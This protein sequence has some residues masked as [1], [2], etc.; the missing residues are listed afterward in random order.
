MYSS[1]SSNGVAFSLFPTL[2]SDVER[3]SSCRIIMACVGEVVE[4]T[5]DRDESYSVS[6]MYV[7]RYYVSPTLLQEFL[8]RNIA[9]VDFSLC[10]PV[11]LPIS[12]RARL[13]ISFF[14]L[15]LFFSLLEMRASRFHNS[16]YSPLFNFSWDS[17]KSR[18]LTRS[19]PC[20]APIGRIHLYKCRIL[21]RV[22]NVATC[23]YIGRT[24]RGRMLRLLWI[25][26]Y[27]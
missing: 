11:T 25:Y 3:S 9:F 8:M 20:P 7:L 16:P 1:R 21:F 26:I 22:R 18:K 12:K 17:R 24:H 13:F 6:Y 5:E 15:L 19:L 14:F 2:I 10:L 27:I 4:I 23:M